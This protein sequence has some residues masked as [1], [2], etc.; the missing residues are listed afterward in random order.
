MRAIN[1][2]RAALSLQLN[3]DPFHLI[4]RHLIIPSII[5]RRRPRRFMRRH[6]LSELPVVTVS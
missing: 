5:E 6:W 2:R 4:H 3:Q 1:I